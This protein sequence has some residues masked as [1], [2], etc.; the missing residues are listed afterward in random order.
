[1]RTPVIPTAPGPWA[2]GRCSRSRRA[3]AT[4][5][6]RES[7]GTLHTYVALAK[8]PDWL[9]GID[10][11]DPTVAAARVAAD[12]FP[13]WAPELTA[14]ITDSD[15]VPVPRQINALPVDH[16]WPRVR[17]V[18]LLGDA[19]HLMSPFAGQGANLAMYDGAEL[20]TAIVTHPDDVET[21][22]SQYEDALFPRAA[23]AAA[24]SAHNHGL[25]FGDDTP[26]GLIRL[27]TG[28]QEPQA[29]TN[30]CAE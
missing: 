19:A 20:A 5:A 4:L 1:M 23:A 6:H 30:E 2:A 14:L 27:I 8:P 16:S 17:G 18:T 24:E 26:D 28:G 25:L 13:G 21:A 15:T 3:G 7:G 9:A 11:D 22:L 29:L 10:L 12:E